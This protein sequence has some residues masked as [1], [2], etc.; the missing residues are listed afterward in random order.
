M[1]IGGQTNQFKMCSVQMRGGLRW[2]YYCFA[3]THTHTHVRY[4]VS[5]LRASLY[6]KLLEHTYVYII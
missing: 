2:Q 6:N 3:R 5:L 4:V 1:G